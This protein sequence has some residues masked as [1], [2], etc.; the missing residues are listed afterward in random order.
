M[1]NNPLKKF[2]RKIIVEAILNSFIYGVVFGCSFSLLLISLFGLIR[3]KS[4]L[5]S[6]ILTLVLVVATSVFFYVKIFNPSEK[7]LAVKVDTLGLENRA[8]TMIENKKNDSL[9]ARLQREDAI[10]HIEKTDVKDYKIR[11]KLK[12]L[13]ISIVLILAVFLAILLIPNK[14]K[15]NNPT[16]DYPSSTEI[17]DSESESSSEEEDREEEIIDKLITDLIEIIDNA[18]VNQELKDQLYEKV[19]K[20]NEDIK[21]EENL[22]TKIDKIKQAKEEIEEIIDEA[23]AEYDI[24][25]A[26]QRFD[27]TEKLGEVISDKAIDKVDNAI[28]LM[29]AYMRSQDNLQQQIDGLKDILNQVLEMATK[30]ENEALIEAIKN[31]KANLLLADD[32]YLSDVMDMAA[33]DIKNALMSDTSMPQD[34]DEKPQMEELQQDINNAIQEA[35][36]ALEQQEEEQGNQDNQ[37]NQDQSDANKPPVIKD[38]PLESEKIID[39]NTPYLSVYDEYYAKILELLAS[40]ETITDEQREFIEKYLE[41]L[42]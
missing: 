12:P 29:E 16:D 7:L 42:K 18:E 38:D 25:K 17:E 13:I 37:E 32:N 28:D 40:D 6:I 9:M 4:T 23:L 26:M 30:E 15:N 21:D 31:F 19:E 10:T 33:E 39:G 2:K 35:L 36:D 11:L 27:L 5:L 20:L 41:M 14:P 8:S 24:G 3:I 22:Q 1:E 34:S